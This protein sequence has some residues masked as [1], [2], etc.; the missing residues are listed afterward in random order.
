MVWTANKT[1]AVLLTALIG[2]WAGALLGLPNWAAIL[3]GVVFAFGT[4]AGIRKR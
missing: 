3:A 2:V 4:W 1:L